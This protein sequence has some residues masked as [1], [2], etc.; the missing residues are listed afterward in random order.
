MI[1]KRTVVDKGTQQMTDMVEEYHQNINIV[2]T[3]KTTKLYTY[4]PECKVGKC[5][6]SFPLSVYLVQGSPYLFVE[7]TFINLHAANS[8]QK[9]L[10]NTS[11]R[12]FLV[13]Y[14]EL[15]EFQFTWD[16]PRRCVS[17]QYKSILWLD[18]LSSC[19][20]GNPGGVLT[21]NWWRGD[22]QT[23]WPPFSQLIRINPVFCQ[24]PIQIVMNQFCRSLWRHRLGSG[25]LLVNCSCSVTP[26]SKILA[27][28][29]MIKQTQLVFAAKLQAEM[30]SL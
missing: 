25:T 21:K 28:G 14:F 22:D 26:W 15:L 7:F 19:R 4:L 17:S 20:L 1:A 11:T 10:L 9:F 8:T 24:Y 27:L 16:K 2:K 29:W 6:E 13:W 30:T 12:N 23:H 3:N 18:K 5:A